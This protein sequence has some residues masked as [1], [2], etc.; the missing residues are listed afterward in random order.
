MEAQYCFLDLGSG[1]DPDAS[2]GSLIPRME[3]KSEGAKHIGQI[4][5]PA[6]RPMEGETGQREHKGTSVRDKWRKKVEEEVKV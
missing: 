6:G 2:G 1:D 5:S 4:R 3:E